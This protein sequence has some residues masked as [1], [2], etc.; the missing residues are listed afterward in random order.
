MGQDLMYKENFMRYVPE[1]L[2]FQYYTMYF[3]IIHKKA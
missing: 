2:H 3:Y 1:H